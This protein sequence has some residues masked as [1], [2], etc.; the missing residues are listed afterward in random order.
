MA[1]RTAVG[2]DIGTSGVRAAELAFGKGPAT[3]QRFGQVALPVGAVRDGE[4]ADPQLVADAIKHLWSTAKFSSKRVVLGVANQKV[5]VRQVDL[6]WMPSDELRKSLPLQVQDFIPIPVEQAILDFHAIEEVQDGA[7]S[8]ALR[9]LLVAA[10]RDMVQGALEAVK[11]AGLTPVQVDLTP[12]AVL[13]SLGR[14]DEVGAATSGSNGGA[15]ALVDVGAKVTNIVIHQ[16]GIPRFVRILL[17]GGDN[18]TDAVSERLGVPFEQAVG[19]KQQLGMA[20][21]RGEVTSDH[22][23]ARVIES[24]AGSFVEEVRGSLDY[25]LAQAASVPLH[26]VVLSGGGARLAGLGQRLAAATRLPVE[27]GAATAA[28]RVG[29]TGLSAD[30]LSYVE[31]Q[32]AVPVGLAMGVAS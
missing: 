2:L 9:V 7:G 5:I 15:E 8:R 24:S 27:P 3:L 17:M 30:Q 31:P 6:P 19:V 21:V 12:F 13:R 32:I 26:R 1:G 28:L 23:A 4:V 10:A 20:P 16:N 11:K 29:K 18:I 22:P 14:V 25:Y